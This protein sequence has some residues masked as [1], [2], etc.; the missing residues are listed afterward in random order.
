MAGSN[1]E[2]V[3]YRTVTQPNTPIAPILHHVEP[4]LFVEAVTDGLNNYLQHKEWQTALGKSASQWLPGREPP[5]FIQW[6]RALNK[7]LLYL[8][9]GPETPLNCSDDSPEMKAAMERRRE[10]KR[11]EKRIKDGDWQEGAQDDDMLPVSSGF[12]TNHASPVHT[13]SSRIAGSAP[14]EA[15]LKE[16]EEKKRKRSSADKTNSIEPQRKKT[17]KMVTAAPVK[18]RRSA[19]LMNATKDNVEPQSKKIRGTTDTTSATPS[20]LRRSTRLKKT[21]MHQCSG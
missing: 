3:T 17:R 18:L 20:K 8:Y 6:Y 15:K 10:I 7:R 1:N 21:R 11:I 13:A 9:C 2:T 16:A 5:E 12:N 19:R 4:R 14:P